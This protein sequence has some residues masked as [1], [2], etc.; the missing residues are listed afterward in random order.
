MNTRSLRVFAEVARTGSFSTAARNL[1][2]TQP[3]VSF[4]V[5]SLEKEYGCTLVDR[6]LGR[7]RLTE[8]GRALLRHAQRILKL[9]EELA[10]EMEGRRGEPSGTLLL[11]ASNIPG[12]YILPRLLSR[13]HERFPLVELRLEVTDTGRVLDLVRAGEVDLGCVGSREKE[14]RLEY[15]RLC[16]DRLVFIAPGDHPMADRKGIAAE[17]LA[18]E[19]LILREEGSGTRLHMLRILSELGLDLSSLDRLVVGSTMAVIQA[20]AAGAGISVSSLW[21]V[22]PYA[23]LGKIRILPLSGP[24]LERDFFYVTLRRRPSTPA[25]EA[26]VQLIE[27]VRPELEDEL[28]S[29]YGPLN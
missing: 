19:T 28:A 20:V 22:E 9:E 11:A 12:E 14:E 15:G 23:R 25:V 8:P 18:G 6:S 3:A 24:D 5:R 16:S 21:A 26:L 7:C 29:L 4:H 13:Y 10:R 1:G 2:L 17:D 27:E